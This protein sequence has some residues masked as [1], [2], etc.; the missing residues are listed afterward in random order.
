M[1]TSKRQRRFKS[2]V[3][4]AGFTLE[5]GKQVTGG[6]P[7][8]KTSNSGADDDAT[9]PPKTPKRSRKTAEPGSS[10]AKRRKSNKKE[11]LKEEPEALEAANE[12]SD[13]EGQGEQ[14]ASGEA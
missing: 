11:E 3:E 1:L 13:Q 14:E 8:A 7:L 6:T 4:R 2:T 9:T 12:A 5:N 10:A